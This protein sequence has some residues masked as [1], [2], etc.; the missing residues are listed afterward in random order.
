MT[1]PPR[2]ESASGL[3]AEWNA[4]GSLRR[5]DCGA[6]AL[7]LFPGNEL[8]GGPAN[9][10]LRRRGAR[11]ETIPLLGPRSPAHYGRSARGFAASGEWGEVRFRVEF[12][13]AHDAAAWFWHV[14]LGNTGRAAVE[15]DLI[16]T[17]DLALAD[18][19]FLRNNEFYTSHYVD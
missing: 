19:G 10:Y 3:R 12:A 8:E 17:Q 6:L 2:L 15:L 9:L 14:A 16:H 7:N 4:N 18:Y 1:A 13:L 11:I 5:I